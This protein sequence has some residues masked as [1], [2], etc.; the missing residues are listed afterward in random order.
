MHLHITLAC[1]DTQRSK[2]E[3]VGQH[4]LLSVRRVQLH[5]V[6]SGTEGR[7]LMLFLHGLLESW[8]SWRHQMNHFSEQFYCV[9]LSLREYETRHAQECAIVTVCEDIRHAVHALGYSSAV[10]VGRVTAWHVA[11]LCPTIVSRLIVMGAPHPVHALWNIRFCLPPSMLCAMLL[12][13]CVRCMSRQ[14]RNWTYA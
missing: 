5:A 11:L 6:A 8:Y 1:A 13:V 7:P 2:R 9:S 14:V 12:T 3:A 10:I 4:L